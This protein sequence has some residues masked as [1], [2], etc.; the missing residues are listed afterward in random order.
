MT[1]L[2][3]YMNGIHIGLLS[4]VNGQLSFVYIDQPAARLAHQLPIQKEAFFMNN[5]NHSSP[6]SFQMSQFAPIWHVC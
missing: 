1:T 5:A 2:L 4:T 6:D 3:V